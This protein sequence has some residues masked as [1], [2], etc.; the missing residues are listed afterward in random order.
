MMMSHIRE[1]ICVKGS[2]K[3]YQQGGIKVYHRV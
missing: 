3:S 2:L 1:Q